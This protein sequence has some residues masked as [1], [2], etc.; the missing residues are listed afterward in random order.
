MEIGEGTVVSLEYTLHLGD[1]KVID[2]SAPN[3]PVKY[4]HGTG[5][6]VPG[7][8]RQLVGANPGDKR[9]IQV[10]PKEGYGEHDPEGVQEVPKSSFPEGAKLEP[11][12]RY[13]AHNKTGD[14]VPLFIREVK[15]DVVL[16]DLNHPLAGETLHFDIFIRDVR[17]ATEEELAHGHT[18]G[19]GGAHE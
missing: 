19:P 14:S 10:E 12:V 2:A 8:E 3:Q 4:L 6:L 11:G 5:Q 7:L 16:I 9:Q 15:E 17:K 18:H 1:G 13:T